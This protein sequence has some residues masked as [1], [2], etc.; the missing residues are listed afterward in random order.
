MVSMMACHSRPLCMVTGE[1]ALPF[2]VHSCSEIQPP[3]GQCYCPFLLWFA[4]CKDLCVGLSQ[5][6]EEDLLIRQMTSRTRKQ[7]ETRRDFEWF[8]GGGGSPTCLGGSMSRRVILE[9]PSAK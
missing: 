3:R 9:G 5:N 7:A 6:V 1:G 2:R 8:P 4:L